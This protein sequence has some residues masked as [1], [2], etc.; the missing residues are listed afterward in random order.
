MATA[1][2]VAFVM[3]GFDVFVQGR[4]RGRYWCVQRHYPDSE[5]KPAPGRLPLR[6]SRSALNAV[7]LR[8]WRLHL[9]NGRMR[10]VPLTPELRCDLLSRAHCDGWIFGEDRCEGGPASQSALTI[11]FRRLMRGL[12]IDGASHHTL[13]HTGASAMVA[14]GVSLRVVQEIDGWTSLRMLERYAH[15][16]GEEMQR[17]E[18]A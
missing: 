4:P 10:R 8:N 16:T 11:A 2:V 5:R 15:P 9:K 7:R 1:S 6:L 3:Y 12:G 14:A 18:S 17:A 13:R